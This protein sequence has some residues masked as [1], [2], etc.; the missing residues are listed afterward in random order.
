VYVGKVG[1]L[2]KKPIGGLKI[3]LEGLKQLPAQ[4][5]G[6]VEDFFLIMP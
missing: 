6:A 3:P 1:K 2:A 4:A 5:L